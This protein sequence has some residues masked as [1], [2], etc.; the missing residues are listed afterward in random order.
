[1]LV[2]ALERASETRVICN[3]VFFL[4]YL[5]RIDLKVFRQSS[6]NRQTKYQVG[7]YFL[8]GF[9]NWKPKQNKRLK[10]IVLP[11]TKNYTITV[12]CSS[13]LRSFLKTTEKSNLIKLKSWRRNF[14]L[15][16]GDKFKTAKREMT[17]FLTMI[18]GFVFSR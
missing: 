7:W 13:F 3:A 11:K 12:A 8:H 4:L 5:D 2:E 18:T 16:K 1:M 10:K 9:H 15:L 17:A 14:G 6:W